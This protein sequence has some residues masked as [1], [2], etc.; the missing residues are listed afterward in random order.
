[1][2]ENYQNQNI[3]NVTTCADSVF[4]SLRFALNQANLL[5]KAKIIIRPNVGNKIILR[6]GELNINSKIELF[7]CTKN[8]ITICVL[9]NNHRILK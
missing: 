6:D 3:F 8:D 2:C 4:G 1:M 9:N 5:P 7:N